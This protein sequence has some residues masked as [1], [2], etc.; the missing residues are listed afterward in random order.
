M[1]VAHPRSSLLLIAS[2]SLAVSSRHLNTS[3]VYSLHNQLSSIAWAV[4]LPLF[5]GA[6]VIGLRDRLAIQRTSPYYC[7][8]HSLGLCV[9]ILFFFAHTAHHFRRGGANMVIGAFLEL[10]SL[11]LSGWTTWLVTRVR[12][13][14][15]SLGTSPSSPIHYSLIVRTLIFS[16]ILFLALAVELFVAL[17]NVTVPVPGVSALIK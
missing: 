11:I 1:N 6:L 2:S 7:L 17:A 16:A 15:C 3:H 12:R 4:G 5:F 14:L 9:L 13:R 8:H 10:C